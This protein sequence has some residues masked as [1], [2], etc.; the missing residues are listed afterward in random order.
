MLLALLATTSISTTPHPTNA[1]DKATWDF[2]HDNLTASILALPPNDLRNLQITQ[3]YS[4][5][6]PLFQELVHSGSGANWPTIAT[7]ASSSVGMGIRKKMLP[8]WVDIVS[9]DWPKW[10]RDLMMASA[11][12][13]DLICDKVLV[14]VS[15][16]LSEGNAFVFNEI[17]GTFSRFGQ[18]F[19]AQSAIG[20]DEKLLARFLDT[21][22]PSSQALLIQ[23][24][25]YYYRSMWEVENRTQLLYYANA[26][27][28]L[29]EQ[30]FRP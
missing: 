10:L 20:P 16:A 9:R 30:V 19:A 17:G 27:V 15:R 21:L 11:E 3:A 12:V 24:F 25:T 23:G 2:Y 29:D 1:R 28:G 6:S 14:H 26:L 4:E 18:F 8:H 7:W 13:A 5:L 22:D